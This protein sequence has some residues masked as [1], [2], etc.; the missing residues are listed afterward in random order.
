MARNP[1]YDTGVAQALKASSI[2]SL[3]YP[4]D[5]TSMSRSDHYVQFF[6]NENVNGSAYFNGGATPSGE[7]NKG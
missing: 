6:I 1:H 3:Q 2:G 7:R 5:I 4:K